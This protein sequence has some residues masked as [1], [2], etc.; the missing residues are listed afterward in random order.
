MCGGDM[1]Q[2]P[3]RQKRER[4]Q[5]AAEGPGRGRKPVDSGLITCEKIPYY[6]YY[7]SLK[8]FLLQ[9]PDQKDSVKYIGLYVFR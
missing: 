3:E 6:T 7:F 1:P 8:A 9:N 2:R 5:A 4:N